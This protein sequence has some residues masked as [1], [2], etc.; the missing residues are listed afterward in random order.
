[1][2][3]C[4]QTIK[5]TLFNLIPLA[6]FATILII[7]LYSPDLTWIAIGASSIALI[8]LMCMSEK[9][10]WKEDVKDLISRILFETLILSLAFHLVGE[11]F[12]G[13]DCDTSPE[14][15]TGLVCTWK[16]SS[17]T[18]NL[19]L[20]G[21]INLLLIT[22]KLPLKRL[23]DRLG[24]SK[25]HRKMDIL[26]RSKKKLSTSDLKNIEPEI[27]FGYLA[28]VNSINTAKARKSDLKIFFDFVRKHLSEKQ[29]QE[30]S[31]TDI[32]YFRNFLL[33]WENN[34]G[35][36]KFSQSSIN[37]MIATL[38]SFFDYC[39]ECKIVELSPV[40]KIKRFSI[41]KKVKSIYLKDESVLNMLKSID[42]TSGAGK[43]HFAILTTLFN[44]G[45]RQGELRDLKV[46]NLIYS[47]NTPSLR[48]LAKGGS[49]VITPINQKTEE[50]I[51]E[52]L[53]WRKKE[54]GFLKMEDPLF[55]SPKTQKKLSSSTINF[56]F[57][58]YAKRAG[59]KE[60]VSAQCARVS[61]ISN[62]KNKGVGI[63]DIAN[64]VGHKDFKTTEN[65][66]KCS[67]DKKRISDMLT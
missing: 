30:I 53:L 32:L 62:L 38:S 6:L 13:N 44:S 61:V 7:H 43:L 12:L 28:N 39:V 23:W 16:K 34:P 20:A 63:D 27:F 64:F 5:Q 14:N 46:R 19:L 25:K 55:C 22:F 24:K 54:L 29:I 52:F 57:K 60:K 59:V 4:W 26:N 56:I 41:E 48:Y 11:A 33:G 49:E 58:K 45:M 2:G 8:L 21:T 31:R 40:T 51:G 42:K 3:T 66:I 65:Y 50:A 17:Y 1:M 15:I 18:H 9:I 36:K 67:M 37:R 10:G 35:H 47:E